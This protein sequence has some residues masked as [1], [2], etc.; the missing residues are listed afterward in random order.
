MGHLG[1]PGHAE[2]QGA[3]AATLSRIAALGPGHA[4]AGANIG[5]AADVAATLALG[6]RFLYASYDAWLKAAARDYLATVR[7]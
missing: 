5:R 2:V 1:D 6:V 7:K 4:V 3:M